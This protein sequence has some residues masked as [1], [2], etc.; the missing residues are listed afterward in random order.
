M[1]G[2]YDENAGAI[3]VLTGLLVHPCT[4][5]AGQLKLFKTDPVS[6]VTR[7]YQSISRDWSK[8][9]KER[10]PESIA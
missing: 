10:I 9:I 7:L 3:F 4:R 6:F 5:P 2:V 8:A 1:D